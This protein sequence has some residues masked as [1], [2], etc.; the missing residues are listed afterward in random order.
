MDRMTDFSLKLLSEAF[1]LRL[2]V[3]GIVPRKISMEL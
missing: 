3:Y 2:G 1:F